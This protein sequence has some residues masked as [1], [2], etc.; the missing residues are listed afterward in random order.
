MQQEADYCVTFRIMLNNS[1][2]ENNAYLISRRGARRCGR[3]I[4]PITCRPF[5]TGGF[6]LVGGGQVARLIR[7]V[8]GAETT[9]I[10]DEII[11][12]LISVN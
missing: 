5:W 4:G 1:L 11:H 8:E 9:K 12:Y 7:V 10:G 3:K 6:L 2:G